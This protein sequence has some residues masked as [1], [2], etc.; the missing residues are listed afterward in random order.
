[1]A[2]SE[3]RIRNCMTELL[4]K[5]EVKGRANLALEADLRGYFPATE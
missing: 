4:R 3:G 5:F 2:L 1:M